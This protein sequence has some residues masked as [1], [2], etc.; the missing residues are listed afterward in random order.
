MIKKIR[1]ELCGCCSIED[2]KGQN[3]QMVEGFS[4]QGIFLYSSFSLFSFSFLKAMRGLW[5]STM[6]FEQRTGLRNEAQC[7]CRQ[8]KQ[9]KQ[10]FVNDKQR[11]GNEDDKISNYKAFK[12]VTIIPL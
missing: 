4:T 2:G 9:F 7:S 3:V 1:K 8:N 5:V 11:M 12:T 10:A 6:L